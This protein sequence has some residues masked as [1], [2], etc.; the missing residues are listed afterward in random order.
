[1]AWDWGGVGTWVTVSHRNTFCLIDAERLWLYSF[2]VTHCY[3][4]DRDAGR[5]FAYTG[6]FAWNWQSP[7]AI[8]HSL[9]FLCIQSIQLLLMF[10]HPA[11]FVTHLSWAAT[12]DNVSVMGIARIGL[13]ETQAL[14][15]LEVQ[16]PWPCSNVWHQDYLKRTIKDKTNAAFN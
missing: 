16:L 11:S 15:G 9:I 3:R 10:P 12:H 1:M 5:A 2:S 8:N 6:L 13:A 7:R 4:M 14:F